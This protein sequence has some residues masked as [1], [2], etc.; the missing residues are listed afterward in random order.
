MAVLISKIMSEDTWKRILQMCSD[1][2]HEVLEVDEVN[3][4]VFVRYQD[5]TEDWIPVY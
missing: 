4:L 5:G 2:G 1:V 3:E